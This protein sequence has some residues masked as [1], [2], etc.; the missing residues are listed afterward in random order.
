MMHNL[1]HGLSSLLPRVSTLLLIWR[2]FDE[3]VMVTRYFYK[4]LQINTTKTWGLLM[5]PNKMDPN[6]SKQAQKTLMGLGTCLEPN[7]F[8]G[9]ST[10]PEPNIHYI[11]FLKPNAGLL[12]FY[13]DQICIILSRIHLKISQRWNSTLSPPLNKRIR[14]MSYKYTMNYS[15]QIFTISLFLIFS[16]Y[17]FSKSISLKY[18]CTFFLSTKLL[19]LPSESPYVYNR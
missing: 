10:H 4:Y 14:F 19:T 18:H 7:T 5:D 16:A 3:L 17:I 11:I 13:I 12:V 9:S 2:K 6:P 15:S 8:M 1:T